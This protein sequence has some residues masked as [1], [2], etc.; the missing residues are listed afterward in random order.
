M[1]KR[2][3]G[4]KSGAASYRVIGRHA[5]HGVSPGDTFT[6]DLDPDHERHLIEGGHLQ[7][8]ELENPD[9]AKSADKER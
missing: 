9:S 6:K 7:I 4:S 5:V 2:S 1:P 8:V 3:A